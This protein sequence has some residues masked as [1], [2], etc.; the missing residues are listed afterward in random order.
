MK[1]FNTRE[2]RQPWVC[3][4]FLECTNERDDLQK[5]AKISNS[6][7]GQI[8]ANRAR[9]RCTSLKRE[10]KRLFFQSSIQE[11]K[12]DAGRLWK[13]LK[14]LLQNTTSMNKINSI[15]D[16][17]DP[18]EIVSELNTYFANIGPELDSKID[19]SNLQLS[20]DNRPNI[21]LLYLQ[22]VTVEEVTKLLM[23]I[24]DAKATGDDG[25]PVKY[26]KMTSY[27]TAN[28]I[29]HI[30]NLSIKHGEIPK[31][32][33]SATITPLFKEGD[34]NS[35]SNYRP[36]SILPAISKILERLIHTQVYE[37]LRTNRLLSEAQF[38]F[39]K[40]HSTST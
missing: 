19:Y 13:A 22:E 18:F 21:P 20:F 6:P 31:D 27:T 39:R 15:N 35:A 34:R 40:Y 24:S 33:K 14:R 38:G 23:A 37:H 3:T 1:I 10:L 30:V 17:Q 16:K 26:L 2:D 25:I 32:W 4:E 5:K 9:N 12:G 29:T 8:I 7:C 28:I 11:S 36:I